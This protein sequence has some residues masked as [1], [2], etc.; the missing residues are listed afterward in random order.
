VPVPEATAG[1]V[2]TGSSCRGVWSVLSELVAVS[3]T[4]RRLGLVWLPTLEAG[5]SPV[6]AGGRALR[7]AVERALHAKDW[8]RTHDGLLIV[9][10][11]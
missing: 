8:H 10:D 11:D 9:A 3:A 7:L 1:V 4:T 6:V 2:E 5:K